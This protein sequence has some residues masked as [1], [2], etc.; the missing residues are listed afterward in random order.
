IAQCGSSSCKLRGRSGSKGCSTLDEI[1]LK[2]I[3][4]ILLHIP[5][6]QFQQ[7][8][9][10]LFLPFPSLLLGLWLLPL[11]PSKLRLHRRRRKPLIKLQLLQRLP[12]SQRLRAHPPL[13]FVQ[14]PLVLPRLPPPLHTTHIHPHLPPPHLAAQL[15]H[16]PHAHAHAH[17]RHT[18]PPPLRHRHRSPIHHHRHRRLRHRHHLP[19]HAPQPCVRPHHTMLQLRLQQRPQLLRLSIELDLQPGRRSVRLA[20]AVQRRREDRAQRGGRV[21]RVLRERGVV[22]GEVG[23]VVGGERY[24]GVDLA[25]WKGGR[26]A[27]AD[28]GAC[29]G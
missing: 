1:N 28:G 6:A 3:D 13:P 16:I 8:L 24:A 11:Q 17:P 5:T 19:H 15:L 7:P 4:R 23:G 25:G 26:G 9:L 10:L 20:P 29:G 21:G 18:N 27:W 22:L 12:R 14:T 2:W